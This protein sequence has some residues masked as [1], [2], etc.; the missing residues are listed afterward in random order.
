MILSCISLNGDILKLYRWIL[1]IQSFGVNLDPHHWFLK[2]LNL[3]VCGLIR[4]KQ[5]QVAHGFR[6]SVSI[7]VEV[8][9]KVG[10]HFNFASN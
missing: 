8:K 7:L 2:Y 6:I 9:F 4:P 1:W 3:D 10:H 5:K